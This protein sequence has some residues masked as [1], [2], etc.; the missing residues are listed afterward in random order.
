ML[1]S[2]PMRFVFVLALVVVLAPASGWAQEVTLSPY[3]SFQVDEAPTALAFSSDGRLL[4][5]GEE[6]GQIVGWDVEQKT[7]VFQARLQEEIQFL[8]FLRG[9]TSFV[10]VDR[11]GTISVGT[12]A[13]NSLNVRFRAEEP[14]AVALDA[15]RRYLAVAMDEQI[16]LF[17]LQT[18][19][20]LGRIDTRDELDDPLFLGFDRLGKQLVAITRQGTVFAWNP[21]TQRL[22]RE[23]ALS[24]GQL[25][26]SRSVIQAAATHRG[27]NL[28]I[29][30]LQEVALP[31]GGLRGRARPGDLVRRNMIIA[32][33]WNSGLEIKRIAYPEGRVG[34]IA[35]GPGSDHVAVT[36]EER[37]TLTLVDLRRGELG[38]TVTVDGSPSVVTVS[39]D[40]R[41]LAVGTERG[42]ITVWALEFSEPP[43][44]ER[45]EA[46]LPT[47]SGR[48]RVLSEKKPAIPQGTSVQLA[49]LPFQGSGEA[50]KVASICSDALTTQLA[51]VEHLTLLERKRIDEVLDELNL[52]ASDL[53]ESDGAR[54]GHLL[55][56]DYLI[57]GSIN[58]LGTTYMFNA[59]LLRVETSQITK[60]RQVICEEC[61][62]Q[63]VFDA[64]HLLGTT[65]AR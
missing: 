9:D 54:I 37:P 44:A 55:N 11:G 56:A 26:G 60:G 16:G 15:G 53:T 25:H 49:I 41:W 35:L 18:G 47:L 38:S 59:R 7:K 43:T 40:D 61:T 27:A 42:G 14:R 28:F 19:M 46:S 29:V 34:R 3:H 21:Q 52:Q 23:L 39:E 32:Y 30:G 6:E 45:Q 12:I 51:N 62:F 8:G 1:I 2:S 57:L 20:T 65:I 31:K 48:I 24:G 13:G 63:D 17:D 4:L 10:S 22:I 64:I 58:A 50:R 36:D 33:D 5:T